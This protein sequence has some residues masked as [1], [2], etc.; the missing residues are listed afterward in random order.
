M[1]QYEEQRPIG[2]DGVQLASKTYD[3]EVGFQ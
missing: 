3:F 1:R 2:F